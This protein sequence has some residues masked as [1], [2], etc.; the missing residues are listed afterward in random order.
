M[1]QGL[2]FYMLFSALLESRWW[3]QAHPA[4]SMPVLFG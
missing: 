4:A 3:R 1:A 2:G